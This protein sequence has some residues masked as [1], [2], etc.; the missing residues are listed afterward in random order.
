MGRKQAQRELS[1]DAEIDALNALGVIHSIR[2][3]KDLDEAPG[4]YKSIKTVMAEQEDLVEILV[5]LTPLCV[6]KG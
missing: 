4:S 6:I 3:T 2:S 1:L 5:E